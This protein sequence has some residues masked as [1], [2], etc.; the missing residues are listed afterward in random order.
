[1][2]SKNFRL[3]LAADFP[4]ADFNNPDNRWHDWYL[5]LPDATPFNNRVVADNGPG[6]SVPPIQDEEPAL[7]LSPRAVPVSQGTA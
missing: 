4:G 2:K 5:Q 6:Q 3:A 7:R 1:M